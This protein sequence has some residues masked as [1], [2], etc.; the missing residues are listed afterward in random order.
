MFRPIQSATRPRFDPFRMA[1]L[2]AGFDARNPAHIVASAGRVS[3]WLDLTG[4]GR[5][6]IQATAANQPE[7]TAGDP[8][9]LPYVKFDGLNY[10][11]ACAP[12]T[13]NQPITMYLLLKQTG[14]TQGR[15]I[16]DGNGGSSTSA[17]L[18]EFTP[19]ISSFGGFTL[20]PTQ[21]LTVGT[22]G[23]FSATFNGTSSYV[24]INRNTALTGNAGTNNAGGFYLGTRGGGAVGNCSAVNVITALLY[25]KAHDVFLANRIIGYLAGR[26]NL[27]V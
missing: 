22:L 13:L 15:W 10:F 24:R 23:I 20:T 19:S 17:W 27:A 21:S 12:F 26:T 2:E 14:W 8:G 6:L 11:M 25:S 9:E 18:W 7:Y 16:A 3:R 1:D 5:D 4:K